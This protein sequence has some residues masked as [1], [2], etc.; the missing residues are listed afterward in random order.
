RS[1]SRGAGADRPR[2]KDNPA[3]GSP[4]AIE[5]LRTSAAGL[6]ACR[7]GLSNTNGPAF[8]SSKEMNAGPISCELTLR[9]HELHDD[10]C[11]EH[12]DHEGEHAG[13]A[14]RHVGEVIRRFFVNML[15]RILYVL[16]EPSPPVRASVFSVT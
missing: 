13:E 4:A 14:H 1:R 2:R 3:Y 12:D 5:R 16:H 7:G 11:R 6:S 9:D 15:A 10:S 8:V